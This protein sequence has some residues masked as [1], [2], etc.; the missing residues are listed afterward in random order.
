MANLTSTLNWQR[1]RRKV[2]DPHF[3]AASFLKRAWQL[4]NEHVVVAAP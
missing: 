2:P 3:Y 4:S 1:S